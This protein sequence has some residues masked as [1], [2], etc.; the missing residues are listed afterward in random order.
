MKLLKHQ[1][2]GL[3]LAKRQPRFAFFWDTGTG[4][5]LLGLSII[6]LKQVKT[7]V[8][9]PKFLL[10]DA[11]LGDAKRFYPELSQQIV[12]FHAVK[13]KQSKVRTIRGASV[14]LI[15]YESLLK[16][17]ELLTDYGFEMLI[18]DESQK[19]KNIKAKITK[20]ILKHHTNF[21]YIY[22]L[23]GTPAP[24]N[25]L[26]YYTQLKLVATEELPKTFYQWRNAYFVS[27]FM[28]WKWQITSSGRYHLQ[29]ILSKYS[30]IVKKEDVLDLHGQFCR[31]IQYDL[32]REE[33]QAYKEMAKN[34]ILEITEDETITATTAITK[35]MKLRQILSG[36]IY[37]EN[38]NPVE[39]G[40]SK[41]KTLKQF[42]DLNTDEQFIIWTQYQYEA[43][44][45]VDELDN[46]K[47]ITGQ[48]P[49]TKRQKIADDFRAG[50]IKYLIAH[51]KTIGH[52]TTFTNVNKAI[53]YSLSYS[54]EEF[55]QSQDRI[56]RYGQT[57]PALYYIMQAGLIDKIIWETLSQKQNNM[58]ILLDKVKKELYN[59]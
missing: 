26:E 36:F 50:R 39:L 8:V 48:T 6:K 4:K 40:N 33:F 2:Q 10:E 30:H 27:D 42:L 45:L 16:Q 31:F 15:N 24:N 58:N 51:P 46:A 52:G 44:K 43:D 7:L 57:K 53:Y 21:K 38:S 17:P 9:A 3:K 23:S 14:L 34:F 59:L 18:L 13:N 1:K 29:K 47:A 55:K 22:L 49:T 20:L 41:L 35:L 12:N 56:Y 5:T 28:G 11:W 32:S 54:Y 19:L 25:E 37:D